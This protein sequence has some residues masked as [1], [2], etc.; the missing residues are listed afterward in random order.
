MIDPNHNFMNGSKGESKPIIPS[1]VG[2]DINDGMSEPDYDRR[3]IIALDLP[4]PEAAEALLSH[5]E[6]MPKPFIK[7]GYQLFFRT[8]P[9]WVAQKKEQGYPI[10]LDLKLHD[11]PQTVAKGVESL[12]RLG[13]D[14][15]TLHAAGGRAMLEA[16]RERAEKWATGLFRTRLLAVTQ[17]TSTDQR[18]MNEE[19]GIPGSVWDAVSRYTRLAHEAGADGVICSGLEAG[20]VKRLTSPRFL[21]VTPG[22]RPRGADRGDQKRVVTPSEAWKDGADFLVVG[23][24]ITQ[25]EN[26]KAV[27][28]AMVEEIRQTRRNPA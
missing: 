7:V 26:P 25:A 24:P 17:L 18:M 15:L 20:H 1:A 21:A 3:I 14:F 10:F 16:A 22:I 4:E 2:Q 19:I 11:I 5:W 9:E 28:D 27:F 12:A 6:G 8:G 23:R 13:V